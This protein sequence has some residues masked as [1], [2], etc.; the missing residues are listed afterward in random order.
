MSQYNSDFIHPTPTRLIIERAQEVRK[1]PTSLCKRR[2]VKAQETGSTAQRSR[3]K[4]LR[5]TGSPS[6]MFREPTVA[7]DLSSM[8]IHVGPTC[9]LCDLNRSMLDPKALQRDAGSCGNLSWRFT[10]LHCA[11][12]SATSSGWTSLALIAACGSKVPCNSR[13]QGP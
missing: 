1:N 4:M 13:M 6:I 5:N 3:M 9:P 12:L 11:M 8:P 2:Q 7:C 10:F